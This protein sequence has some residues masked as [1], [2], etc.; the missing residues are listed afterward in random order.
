[1]N[2]F[3]ILTYALDISQQGLLI[4]KN[5]NNLVE[6]KN[7]GYYDPIV[8]YSD[9]YQHVLTPLF[10]MMPLV[11]AWRFNGP[12]ISTNIETTQYM[13]KC[14]GTEQKFFYVMD[15]EWLNMKQLIFKHLNKIYNND[16]IHLIA[17][18][19]LHADVLTKCWKK[20]IAIIPNFNY[21]QIIELIFNYEKA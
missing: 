9:Y 6:D 7:I 13:M 17:R 19:K 1:M 5:M 15:L 16:S 21:T 12:L 11:E 3:G 2:K 14:I 4:T 18:S 8:F 10:A 20:P